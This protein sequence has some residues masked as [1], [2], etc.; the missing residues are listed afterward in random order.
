MLST[1][2]GRPTKLLNVSAHFVRRPVRRRRRLRNNPTHRCSPCGCRPGK[3][4]A[5]PWVL[6]PTALP[7]RRPARRPAPAPSSVEKT[8]KETAKGNDTFTDRALTADHDLHRKG[9]IDSH[10]D[11]GKARAGLRRLASFR[12]A[13]A[14]MDIPMDDFFTG[15]GL[16]PA[17][18]SP[19]TD[20]NPPPTPSLH[21]TRAS[22]LFSH[23][24][25][26]AGHAGEYA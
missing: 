25:H 10:S 26:T 13:V 20:C 1:S 16:P 22:A 17:I 14:G 7:I 12:M 2:L 11:R 18:P 4:G 8:N 24:S 9:C 3:C 5:K 15:V 23:K 6:M 21:A 19:R